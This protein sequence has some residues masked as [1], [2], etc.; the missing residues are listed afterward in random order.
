MIYIIK[1]YKSTTL[2]DIR[3]SF[4]PV[5]P[6]LWLPIFKSHIHVL[7]VIVKEND[8]NVSQSADDQACCKA[9]ARTIPQELPAADYGVGE[10]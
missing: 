10:S 5:L 2:Q 3:L 8:T 1:Y 4:Q 9:L 7:I 6:T